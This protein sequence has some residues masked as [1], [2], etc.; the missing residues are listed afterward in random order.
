M[1]SR[2]CCNF[3]ISLYTL[4]LI[5]LIRNTIC[6]LQVPQIGILASTKTQS[7]DLNKKDIFTIYKY[8]YVKLIP[9][10]LGL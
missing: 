1:A 9:E 8:N 5:L 7:Q 3:C 4:V 10:T 2:K 6:S